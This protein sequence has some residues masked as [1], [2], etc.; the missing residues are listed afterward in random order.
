MP[1]APP[2]FT[3][4]S[5]ED[6]TELMTPPTGGASIL[7]GAP[8]P[9][10]E[11]IGDFEVLGKLGAGGMGA[12]YRA[13]QISLGR[14]VALKVLPPHMIQD[15]E[16]VS[17]FQREARVAASLSHAHLVRVFAAGEAGGVHYIAMELIEGEDLGRRLKREGRLPAPEAL[18]IAAE[19]ARGLDYAWRSAQLIHRDIKPANIFLTSAG[20]VKVGDLGLAKSVLGQNSGLTQTGTMMGTPHYISPEQARADKEIDFR[21]DIY[22]LG[23]T[24][25]QMLTGSVPYA[26]TDPITIIR[27]HLDAPLPA[28]MK[29]WPQCPLPLARLVAKT[30]KKSRHERHA[31]YTELI[32]QIESLWA[33]LDPQSFAPDTFAPPSAPAP[34]SASG[35]AFRGTAGAPGESPRSSGKQTVAATASIPARAKS[36]LPLYCG[37][38]AG[39]LAL[40]IG[41]V[42]FVLS[43]KKEPLT[44]AQ[45]YAAE[46]AAEEAARKFAVPSRSATASPD[47]RVARPQLPAIKLWNTELGLPKKAGVSWTDNALK[48]DNADVQLAAPRTRDVIL[49]ATVRADPGGKSA[50]IAV[51]VLRGECYRLMVDAATRVLHLDLVRDSDKHTPITSWKLPA[52]SFRD[53]WVTM[54]LRAEKD[55]L[56]AS[57]NGQVLG[58]ARDATFAQP[59]GVMLFGRNASYRDIEY[60]PLDG[61][62]AAN[63]PNTAEP[64]RD[65][66]SDPKLVNTLRTS[67]YTP[68]GLRV[69]EQGMVRIRSTGHGQRDGAVRLRQNFGSERLRAAV[70]ESETGMYRLYA[71]DEKTIQLERWER[72]PSRTVVLGL[73]PLSFPLRAGEPYELEL[74]IVGQTLTA[75]CQGEL[76][77]TVTDAAFSAKHF[78]V[79]V[80]GPI[81]QPTLIT[82]LSYLDLDTPAGP[83]AAPLVAAGASV[84]LLPLVQLPRD[85][86]AGEW[87]RTADGLVLTSDGTQ[88]EGGP[89]IEIPFRPPEE[90]DLELDFTVR[91]TGRDVFAMLASGPVGFV[92]RMGKP[93]AGAIFFGFDLLDG[94]QL[95]K[96]PEAVASR[97]APLA[98]GRHTST[99]E[100]RRGRL[101]GS[102]DAGP[103]VEWSGDFQRFQIHQM[104]KPRTHRHL[105]LG[106]WQRDVTF[107]RA[108]LRPIGEATAPALAATAASGTPATA[109]KDTPFVNTLRMKFLPVPITGGPTDGQRVLFSIWETREQDF[110]AFTD[111]T[112]SPGPR[113]SRGVQAPVFSASWI[114]ATA[115]CHW[116]TERERKSGNLPADQ[117]YRLPSDH[118]WSC[119]VGLGESE[120]SG[121]LASEKD[122]KN[123]GVYPWGTT[124]PPPDRAGNYAGEE[125]SPLAAAGT[126]KGGVLTGYRDG[127][128]TAAPVGKFPANAA[129]LYD[130]GGNLREWCL[131]WH[132]KEQTSR[133]TRG[134]AWSEQ[135]Q[136][137]LLSS[138]RM[139]FPP[140][141]HYNPIGF[142]V[143]LAPVP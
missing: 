13:R 29:V 39:V 80:S 107:H 96:R 32:V 119:A 100:V 8:A 113:G 19:T 34:A 17:R 116:L 139:H 75:R 71:A 22:S 77:G 11:M 70:R 95:E 25:Y 111:A 18:R 98:V 137:S 129:G 30:L 14:M 45:R 15:A 136:G 64:W 44:A 103:S 27:Q 112:Q 94:L 69:T 57:I 38:A 52:G 63:T 58:T 60:I 128:T 85:V 67:T 122:R 101:K 10:S 35:T 126:H 41:G 82:G 121:K 53:G 134:G 7:P 3:P 37:L 86:I 84:E 4:D 115:F 28:I 110:Q 1:E 92:W 76:L 117:A 118:E 42:F 43:T 141:F 55:Q 51:R 48:L 81:T 102:V 90:Y 68:E 133:V 66:L 97:T 135:Q 83:A 127:F 12:V 21:A 99:I 26:G 87:T 124:W 132:Q 40:A 142:R 24:L 73:Y 140:D 49:R 88:P 89:R 130:M 46:R 20:A 125:M 79:N 123:E 120:D 62:A 72:E 23:C 143:V 105:G 93:E 65:M 47:L 5:P 74:R 9:V 50:Q 54:E 108:T 59:G 106:A 6:V 131:D 61:A 114:E 33:Q 36:K 2:D 56:T 138:S 16:S 91:G 109:S 31:S 78:G 104:E